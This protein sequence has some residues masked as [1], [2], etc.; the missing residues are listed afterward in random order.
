MLPTQTQNSMKMSEQKSNESSSELKLNEGEN[1]TSAVLN[2]TNNNCAHSKIPGS[3]QPN[4]DDNN[5]LQNEG[6]S[7]KN[8][9]PKSDAD[10]N[11]ERRMKMIRKHRHRCIFWKMVYCNHKKDSNSTFE[12]ETVSSTIYRHTCQLL[13]FGDYLFENKYGG[14]SEDDV[15]GHN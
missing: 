11:K 2:T 7:Q 12:G 14:N 15:D 5:G 13:S 4:I 8:K 1:A 10:T 9:E 3:V 6:N